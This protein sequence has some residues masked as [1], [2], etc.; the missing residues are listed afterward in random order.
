MTWEAIGAL[1][2]VVGA[3]AVIATLIYLSAQIRSNTMSNRNA[4]LQTVSAQ[5]ADWLSLITQDAE[6]ARIF[7]S[8]QQDL[9]NLEGEDLLRY[10]MLMTQFCRVF[11]AQCH[12]YQNKALPDDL[13]QSSLRSIVFIL[14]RRGARSWWESFGYQYSES[15]QKLVATMLEE[16]SAKMR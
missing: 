10:G 12:Q 7:R 2:E 1:G 6:V 8:G 4:A 3:I 16:D 5:N 9:D 13:W 15:F 11:D 14:R